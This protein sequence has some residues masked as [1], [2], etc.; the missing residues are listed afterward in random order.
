VDF[1]GIESS[2]FY[3]E[4]EMIITPHKIYELKDYQICQLNREELREFNQNTLKLVLSEVRENIKNGTLRNLVEE[5][6]C[7]SPETM[8]ALRILDRDYHE[9]IDVY[10]HL[11]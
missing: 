3:S 7:S 4:L 2:D 1:F 5:R 6:C 10:T 9:Y 8:T 11:Y